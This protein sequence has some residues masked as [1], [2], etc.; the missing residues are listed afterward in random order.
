MLKLVLAALICGALFAAGAARAEDM[1][2]RLE[3]LQNGAPSTGN[4]NDAGANHAEG[5][6]SAAFMNA[7]LH[8]M[9]LDERRIATETAVTQQHLD[10]MN[11]AAER[12]ATFR[13]IEQIV[14]PCPMGGTRVNST[15][16]VVGQ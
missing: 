3:A 8:Q 15:T 10:E 12:E 7:A 1:N 4:V 9:A 11:R 5:A 14:N 16:C 13:R 6:T 2:A